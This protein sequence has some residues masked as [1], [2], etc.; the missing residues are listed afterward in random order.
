MPSETQASWSGSLKSKK[1]SELQQICRQLDIEYKSDSLKAELEQ[2]IRHRFHEVPSLQEDERFVRL[3]HTSSPSTSPSTSIPGSRRG[4]RARSASRPPRAANDEDP[5]S[6][7]EDNPTRPT[8]SPSRRTTLDQNSAESAPPTGTQKILVT[9]VN[10]EKDLSRNHT[11]SKT[12]AVPTQPA[13]QAQQL[14]KQ[15]SRQA[16]DSFNA[17]ARY[18]ARQTINIIQTIQKTFSC[19]WKL[20]VIAILA[21]LAFVIYSTV[22]HRHGNYVQPKPDGYPISIPEPMIRLF[23]RIFSKSF[24][25]PF[26]GYLG[27]TVVIPFIIGGLMNVPSSSQE[28]DNKPKFKATRDLKPSVFV[29]SATR[30]AVLSLVHLVFY[31]NYHFGWAN[32]TIHPSPPLNPSPSFEGGDLFPK[33]FFTN[34]QLTGFEYLQ[35]V[36]TTFGML[37]ALHRLI[38]PSA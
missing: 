18:T 12:K 37:I 6:S 29:Y 36:T 16:L 31:P 20:C 13:D 5:Q 38:R 8:R 17:F 27:L 23:Y 1:K 4:T 22:P 35:Y 14:A 15:T 28:K 9:V 3:D 2:Q 25:R 19:P 30:L 10:T 32:Q 34:I 26:A 11:S 24:L 33:H 21:E 7:T